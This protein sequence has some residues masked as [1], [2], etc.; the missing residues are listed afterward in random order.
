MADVV[1]EYYRTVDGDTVDLIAFRRFG[2]SSK[3]TESILDANAGLAARHARDPKLPAGL[4]I[5]V[6]VPVKKDR[7]QST[8]LWS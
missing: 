7:R 3:T 5:R 6:P 1:F 2:T 4:V 8:R